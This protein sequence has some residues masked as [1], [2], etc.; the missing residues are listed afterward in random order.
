MFVMIPIFNSI[1]SN[2]ELHFDGIIY[3]TVPITTAITILGSLVLLLKLSL[4]VFQPRSIELRWQD[5]VLYLGERP[6]QFGVSHKAGTPVKLAQSKADRILTLKLNAALDP[7]SYRMNWFNQ[8]GILKASAKGYI[9]DTPVTAIELA[10]ADKVVCVVTQE[11]PFFRGT[12]A[13]S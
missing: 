5:E 8:A 4:F 11:D 12:G 1:Q 9:A 13:H 6:I 2:P 10:L 3:R 7:Y